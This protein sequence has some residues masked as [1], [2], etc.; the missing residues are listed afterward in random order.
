MEK[1][2]SEKVEAEDDARQLTNSPSV[3]PIEFEARAR[4]RLVGIDSISS[5]LKRPLIEH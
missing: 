4:S 1:D 5:S 2:Q 3:R